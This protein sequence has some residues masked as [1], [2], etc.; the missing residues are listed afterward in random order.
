MANSL[1]CLN[2]LVSRRCLADVLLL[3]W[4]E[5][6]PLSAF[7]QQGVEQCWI[8]IIRRPRSEPKTFIEETT[9]GSDGSSEKR[10]QRW[11]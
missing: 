8:A 9:G 5:N 6:V 11:W 7:T 4:Y 3:F 1:L 2:K 10:G